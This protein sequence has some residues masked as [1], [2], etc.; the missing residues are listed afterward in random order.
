MFLQVLFLALFNKE[1]IETFRWRELQIE[2]TEETL[3][4]SSKGPAEGK[5][6]ALNLERLEVGEVTLAVLK[7][8]GPT[9]DPLVALKTELGKPVFPFKVALM[10][11]VNMFP[12]IG[13]TDAVES[14]DSWSANLQQPSI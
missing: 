14:K 1:L 12:P 7:P 13:D 10:A 6:I 2:E 9:G 8:S 5:W 11:T 4:S 3:S